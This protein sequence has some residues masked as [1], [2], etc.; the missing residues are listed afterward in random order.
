MI[1][2]ND[3]RHEE[4]KGRRKTGLQITQ[5]GHLRGMRGCWQ[6]VPRF[7]AQGTRV[8]KLEDDLLARESRTVDGRR[9]ARADLVRDGRLEGCAAP[10]DQAQ[11]LPAKKLWRAVTKGVQDAL[12]LIGVVNEGRACARQP[13]RLHDAGHSGSLHDHRRSPVEQQSR[14]TQTP[15]LGEEQR[16]AVRARLTVPCHVLV[17]LVRALFKLHHRDGGSLKCGC[18]RAFVP[19]WRLD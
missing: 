7:Q 14:R 17:E 9:T 1:R 18:M 4:C 3:T 6:V 10:V 2:R 11:G 15:R 8:R 12:D 13:V 5:N 16:L 19:W